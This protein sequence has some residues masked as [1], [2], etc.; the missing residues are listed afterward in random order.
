MEVG[1]E[2]NKKENKAEEEEE[3][4]HLIVFIRFYARNENI[5]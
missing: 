3:D 2:K 4:V 5:G 1:G